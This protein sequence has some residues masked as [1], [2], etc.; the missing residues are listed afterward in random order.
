MFNNIL[1]SLK[2][3]VPPVK[4]LE[5]SGISGMDI[6]AL[7][8]LQGKLNERD[9]EN[10]EKFNALYEGALN[11]LNIFADNPEENSESL[12]DAT[13]KF[14][15]A[16]E[17]KRNRAEPYFYLS[18]IAYFLDDMELSLKYL[19]IAKQLN[20]DFQPLKEFMNEINSIEDEKENDS[21]ELYS[22]K[23]K[24]NKQ[25]VSNKKEI[26]LDMNKSSL[27]KKSTEIKPI[28]RVKRL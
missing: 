3:K 11:Y 2:N 23:D 25:D 5:N 27:P 4:A 10:D 24:E 8:G 26:R 6:E 12:R 7:K 17:V 22:L 28:T 19:Q 16:I 20:S 18:Y 15:E 1:K 14:S 9:E 21:D 13:E